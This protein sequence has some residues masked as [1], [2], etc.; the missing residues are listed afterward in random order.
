MARISSLLFL[1]TLI[2]LVNSSELRPGAQTFNLDKP[3]AVSDYLE[4]MTWQ[5][6]AELS[7]CPCSETQVKNLQLIYDQAIVKCSAF[8]SPD[9]QSSAEDLM[10]LRLKSRE[11]Q[12]AFQNRF[13][14]KLNKKIAECGG[15]R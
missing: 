13:T 5:A 6:E 2:P 1:F 11:A 7:R 15:A 14:V 4:C 10:Q 9:V 12:A 3:A 8:V